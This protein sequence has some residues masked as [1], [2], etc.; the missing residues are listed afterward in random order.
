MKYTFRKVLLNIS[1]PYPENHECAGLIQ[2]LSAKITK[3][4]F[5]MFAKYCKVSKMTGNYLKINDNVKFV[6]DVLKLAVL[7]RGAVSAPL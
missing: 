6:N 4:L 7:I 3:I 2:P 1:D 5:R